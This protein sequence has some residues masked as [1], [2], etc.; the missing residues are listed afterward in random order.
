MDWIFIRPFL[1]PGAVSQDRERGQFLF[2]VMKNPRYTGRLGPE[3]GREAMIFKALRSWRCFSRGRS[4]QKRR[5]SG[6]MQ[7]GSN[8]RTR[9]RQNEH[10]EGKK[11]S[12]DTRIVDS[13]STC[14]RK[15]GH[16]NFLTLPLL[17]RENPCNEFESGC[18]C[19]NE[20]SQFTGEEGC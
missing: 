4:D 18:Q 16:R 15:K 5:Q 9:M 17:C 1:W 10:F 19:Q 14:N 12:N 2:Q 7:D 6:Q 11:E 13:R 20:S 8:L 3:S